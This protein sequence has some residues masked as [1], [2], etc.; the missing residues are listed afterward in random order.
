[1]CACVRAC[2]YYISSYES[3]L[4]PATF[5]TGVLGDAWWSPLTSEV[6]FLIILL[7]SGYLLATKCLPGA[8]VWT[9]YMELS[10]ELDF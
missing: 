3:S 8:A 9:P 10:G 5:S 2:V 4:G 1:M 7:L 6:L